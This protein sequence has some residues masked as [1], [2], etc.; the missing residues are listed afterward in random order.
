MWYGLICWY[1][2]CL[3]GPSIQDYGTVHDGMSYE[4]VT[5]PLT[6]YEAEKE[7][8]SRGMVLAMHEGTVSDQPLPFIEYTDLSGQ[9]WFSAT[10][11]RNDCFD[12]DFYIWAWTQ[13][14]EELMDLPY[15][16]PRG[17]SP[18]CLTLGVVED[19]LLFHGMDCLERH[20]A[21]CSQT[22]YP[23]YPVCACARFVA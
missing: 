18:L 23:V 5:T 3:V 10:N 16:I 13:T 2:V 20:Y 19:V 12:S 1:I 15:F 6:F 21:L 9:I 22:R 4:L 11:C 8:K 14:I 7:C 17:S